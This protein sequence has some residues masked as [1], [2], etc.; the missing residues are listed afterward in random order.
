[1]A[2]KFPHFALPVAPPLSPAEFDPALA[3]LLASPP[4]PLP[5]LVLKIA[6]ALVAVALVW[7]AVGR[8]DIVA[9]APG[10]LVPQTYVKIVQPT[11]AG[12]V[13]EILVREGEQVQA[14]QVLM[15]MDPTL[16]AADLA[17]VRREHERKRLGLRRIDAELA[18]RPFVME[19]GDAMSVFAEIQAQY[20]ANRHALAAAVDQERAGHER[21]RQ[22][23][24]AAEQTRD[25]LA[26][27]LP[28]Y[29]EQE[30]AFRKL[31]ADGFSGKLMANDKARERIEK[32]QDLKTQEHV[33][34]RERANMVQSERRVAQ[35]RSDNVRQLQNERAETADRFEKLAQEL[36]KQDHRHGL[37]ELKAPQ[38]GRVK[39]LA[40]HTTGTVTQP[41]T[42]LMTLVP[43]AETL[44]AEVWL[45]NDD[46]GFVRPG[47]EVKLKL[48]AFQ[49]QKYGMVDGRVEQI[50]ADAAEKTDG[51]QKLP[52]MAYRTLVSLNRQT[53]AV[54]GV[55]YRLAPGMQ[56]AAE[57]KLGERTILEYLLSPVQKAWHE[58]GRER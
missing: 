5:K 47:Q 39:D 12:V 7:A 27:T 30:A 57:V 40:T 41:G 31:T 16:S 29:R 52:Q 28:M 6:L 38:N 56:L 22:E 50:A 8:L 20:T 17:G 23:M 3:R 26:Q 1:M 14:G 10:R 43:D 4:P 32:E 48:A 18:E 35:I 55:P 2:I 37:L 58:A 24:Q 33:I 15:R 42:I 51:D 25:K 44:H 53:L 49:F 11:E 54:D 36:A 9:V 21:S 45:A 13:R 46:V 34:A 19:S